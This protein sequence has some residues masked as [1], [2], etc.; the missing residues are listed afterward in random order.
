MHPIIKSGLSKLNFEL[1]RNPKIEKMPD[2]RSYI[3]EPYKAVFTLSADFELAWAWRFSKGYANPLEGALQRARLARHNM[4]QLLD[5]C[6]TF[7]IPVTWATVGHLFLESCEC[8][9]GKAHPEMERLPHFENP[10]WKFDTGDWFKDDPCSNYRQAPEWYCPDL[11]DRIQASRLQHEIGCHT[12][13]HIDCR[14]G[15]CPPEVFASEITRCQEV[16]RSRGVELKTLI[17]PAHT[18]GNLDTLARL[19]FTNYRSNL[20]N[21]LGYPVLHSNG[22]WEIKSSFQLELREG[23]SVDYQIYRAC[24]VIDRALQNH[25][26]CHF[27]FHPSFPAS[28]LNEVFPAVMAYLHDRRSEILITTMKDYVDWLNDEVATFPLPDNLQNTNR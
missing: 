24:K 17:Y 19:G 13:S 2:D 26:V 14:D 15:V 23:W 12:F 20:D 3:P 1:G 8:E 9:N 22:L 5:I 6:E 10:Y 21:T 11:L 27:W 16:A 4:P 18:V 28:Y 7:S 25:S